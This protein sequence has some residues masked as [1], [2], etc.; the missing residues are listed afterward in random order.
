MRASLQNLQSF[1]L[2]VL[3]VF[4]ILLG[5]LLSPISIIQGSGDDDLEN[6]TPPKSIQKSKGDWIYGKIEYEHDL[7]APNRYFM[8][9]R[10]HPGQP[11]PLLT[12]GYA[13]TDVYAIVQLRNVSTPREL[14]HAKDRNRPHD[15]LSNERDKWNKSLQYIWN[16]TD[17]NHTFKVH[18]LKVIEQSGDKMLEADLEVYLGG[19]WMSLGIMMMNDG[20]ARPKQQDGSE[21]DWGMQSVPLLNPNVPK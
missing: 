2:L 18:N 13:T 3:I 21:W 20:H 19:Q 6:L 12:G 9:L 5:Q 7:I 17:P 15:W 8:L 14:Q 1:K 11:V 4:S 16:L 10:A